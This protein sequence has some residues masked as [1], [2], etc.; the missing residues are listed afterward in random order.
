MQ[1][2]TQNRQHVCAQH[3]TCSTQHSRTTLALVQHTTPSFVHRTVHNI[4]HTGADACLS[5]GCHLS[6]L[7]RNRC[8]ALRV[9]VA[10]LASVSQ[11]WFVYRCTSVIALLA[12]RAA[13]VGGAHGAAGTGRCNTVQDVATCTTLQHTTCCNV[14]EAVELSVAQL[15]CTNLVE[16]DPWPQALQLSATCCNEGHGSCPPVCTHGC[17]DTHACAC[18]R[19]QLCGTLELA[20]LPYASAALVLWPCRCGWFAVWAVQRSRRS[21]RTRTMRRGSGRQCCKTATPV[22]FGMRTPGGAPREAA[23]R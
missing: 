1:R 17:I 15:R 19:A 2:D 7:E 18:K 14:Q 16:E 21:W 22:P 12:I 9:I 20:W 4:Q 3:I 6:L 11:A 23:F 8:A 5:D 10:V 13:A